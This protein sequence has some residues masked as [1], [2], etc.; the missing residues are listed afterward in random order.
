M[1]QLALVI[2]LL[3]LPT[4]RAEV[5]PAE[6]LRTTT[7][8]STGAALLATD[9]RAARDAALDRVT[10]DAAALQLLIAQKQL[11]ADVAWAEAR[12]RDGPPESAPAEAQYRADLEAARAGY[13]ASVAKTPPGPTAGTPVTTPG[14]APGSGQGVQVAGASG[15][16]LTLTY[17]DG[18]LVRLTREGD[19]LAVRMLAAGTYRKPLTQRVHFDDGMI[20]EVT[21]EGAAASARVLAAGRPTPYV[22]GYGSY[23]AAYGYGG[24]AATPYYAAGG[25]TTARSGQHVQVLDDRGERAYIEGPDGSYTQLT[26]SGGRVDVRQIRPPSR[27]VPWQS[28]VVF[29]GG[30]RAEVEGAGGRVTV[31][32]VGPTPVSPAQRIEVRGEAGQR[33]DP[34]RPPVTTP[35]APAT[36]PPPNFLNDPNGAIAVV[37][38][39]EQEVDALRMVYLNALVGALGRAD[40]DIEAGAALS[41]A[42]R[43]PALAG[44]VEA[45]RLSGAASHHTYRTGVEQAARD[46]DAL[47]ATAPR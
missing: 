7:A 27:S 11:D 24:Y 5:S 3:G 31:R 36:T 26:Y 46:L 29:S 15:E 16:R 45:L 33:P 6:E 20:V 22:G 13:W 34:P 37:A 35:I 10:A 21:R 8:A 23:A 42:Q 4:A 38:R 44:A 12:R 14:P 1:V 2:S 30:T 19:S 39:F 9:A 17:S 43:A 40:A 41:P 25:G 32:S 18:A 47:S 28:L